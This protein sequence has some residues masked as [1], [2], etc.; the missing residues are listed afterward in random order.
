MAT[1]LTPLVAVELGSVSIHALKSTLRSCSR[2]DEESKLET[3]L[4]GSA[5]ATWTAC[6]TS[7]VTTFSRMSLATVSVSSL[8]CAHVPPTDG[9]FSRGRSPPVDGVLER[10]RLHTRHSHRQPSRSSETAAALEAA[11][12]ELWQVP[13]VAS[14]AAHIAHFL[15]LSG[16]RNVHTE[17]P[18]CISKPLVELS[19]A[20]PPPPS[21]E[22]DCL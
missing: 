19:R 20:P 8:E 11:A 14:G 16:L 15:E 21:G 2:S 17:H 7:S 18:S 9:S 12:E 4:D 10:K 13:A 6:F 1:S 5:N 3:R 22:S